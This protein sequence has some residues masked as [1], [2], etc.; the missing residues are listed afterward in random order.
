MTGVNILL[1][2]RFD[3]KRAFEKTGEII[4]DGNN[5]GSVQR[6]F[7]TYDEGHISYE[8]IMKFVTSSKSEMLNEVQKNMRIISHLC[9]CE[10]CRSIKNKMI[11][12]EAELDL[13]LSL[14]RDINNK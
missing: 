8:E 1:N 14:V 3:K 2:N 7:Y 12:S 13:A 5:F 6:E 4:D 10:Y 9:Q 11:N